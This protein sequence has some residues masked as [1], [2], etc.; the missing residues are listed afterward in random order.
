[1]WT[2]TKAL[3]L[4]LLTVDLQVNGAVENA[5]GSAA[6]HPKP[7]E[8]I[9]MESPK[10]IDNT[11]ASKT[12]SDFKG[13]LLVIPM[14]GSHWI[15]LKAVA[16]EMGRRGHRVTV[17]MPEVNMRMGPGKH[18]DALFFPVPYN[19]STINSLL[20]SNKNLIR[21]D[22]SSFFENINKR[23]GQIK[24]IKNFIVTTAESLLYND[25]LISHLAQQ[26]SP[27]TQEKKRHW[28]KFC[29]LNDNNTNMLYFSAIVCTA[30]FNFFATHFLFRPSHKMCH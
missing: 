6:E 12:S 5:G 7:E 21:K 11:P 3:V 20:D 14:D 30:G 1:M 15:D 26:V 19:M 29:L 16:Q 13:N 10:G 18:Y 9:R 25:S 17:V 27:T 23:L 2:G 24:L 4:L 28:V 8:M 22:E